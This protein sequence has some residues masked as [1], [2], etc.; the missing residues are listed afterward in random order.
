MVFLI[1]ERREDGTKTGKELACAFVDTC[2]DIDAVDGGAAL[3]R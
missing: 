1:D 3:P 2:D